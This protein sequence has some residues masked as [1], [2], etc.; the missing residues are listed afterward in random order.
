MSG[1]CSLIIPQ[2]DTTTVAEQLETP[3]ARRLVSRG[4]S[5]YLM[6]DGRTNV[7]S[8]ERPEGAFA[9]AICVRDLHPEA[10]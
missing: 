8:I 3:T 1:L 4:A 10:A 5:L 9:K 2:T 6:K 7:L